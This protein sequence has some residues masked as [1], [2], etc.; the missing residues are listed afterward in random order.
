MNNITHRLGYEQIYLERL[1]ETKSMITF[2]SLLEALDQGIDQGLNYHNLMEEAYIVAQHANPNG[3]PT[4]TPDIS[5]ITSVIRSNIKI[6]IYNI[7]EFSITN[8]LQAIYDKIKDEQCGYIDISESL[9]AVWHHTRI[10]NSLQDPNANNNTVERI[11]KQLL[12]D[13]ISNSTLRFNAKKSIPGGNLDGEKIIR[14][15]KD[16]GVAIHPSCCSY[17]ENELKD[18]KDR[19]NDLAHGSVSFTEAGNQVTTSELAELSDNVDSFLQ[20]LKKDVIDY[21]NNGE[22]RS[23]AEK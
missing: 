22:Y 16:H 18:I 6:M 10:K 2:V 5:C 12:D 15:F 23:R 1:R 8:L 13:A 14:L 17:R 11:S 4:Q 21:L 7:I 3:L 19:R 9:Q 20:Q